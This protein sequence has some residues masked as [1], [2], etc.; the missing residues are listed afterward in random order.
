MVNYP[1]PTLLHNGY[2]PHIDNDKFKSQD[3]TYNSFS[4]FERQTETI[5][6]SRTA[7]LFVVSLTLSLY[8]STT[9]GKFVT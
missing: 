7:P 4:H 9:F 1:Y 6:L 8:H 3:F 2:T 5:K